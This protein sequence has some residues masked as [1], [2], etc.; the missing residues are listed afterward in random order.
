MSLLKTTSVFVLLFLSL[1]TH[2]AD[3]DIYSHKKHG[4]VRGADVVAYFSLE[5]GDKAILGD[6]EV[7]HDH[8]GARWYFSTTENRDLFK[9]SPDKYAPKYG[10]YCAFAVSHGFTKPIDPDYWHIVDGELYLNFNFFADR[11][12]RK[13]RDAAIVRADNNWPNVLEACEEHDNCAK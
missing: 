11:K 1:A 12:W 13:D 9:A 3:P 5:P 10:G 7:F 4:A 8:Q 2:A 6:K